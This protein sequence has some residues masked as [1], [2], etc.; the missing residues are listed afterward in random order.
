MDGVV[1]KSAAVCVRCVCTFMYVCVCVVHVFDG[2]IW[3]EVVGGS[4]NEAL[5]GRYACLGLKQRT[6]RCCH[7]SCLPASG[8]IYWVI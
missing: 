6:V 1:F 2:G 4:A 5:M 8:Y 7:S 3:E